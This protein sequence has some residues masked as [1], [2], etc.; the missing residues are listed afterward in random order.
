MFIKHSTPILV[1]ITS[2]AILVSICAS[3]SRHREPSYRGHTLSY[4]LAGLEPTI[5]TSDHEMKG[6][7]YPK[8]RDMGAAKRWMTETENQRRELARR[9]SDVLA[10]ADSECLPILL[11]QL[12]IPPRAQQKPVRSPGGVL[13]QWAFTLGLVGSAPIVEEDHI[14]VQRGQA[15]SAIVLLGNRATPLVPKLSQLAAA[16]RQD[17]IT[18]AASYALHRIAP[19][20]FER[21]RSLKRLGVRIDN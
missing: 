15:L 3:L 12:T 10:E 21:I 18:R 17:A 2:A 11:A 7:S 1:S 9:C 16:E 13:R 8:F 5:I 4:W 20:E 14:E 6:W 19:D